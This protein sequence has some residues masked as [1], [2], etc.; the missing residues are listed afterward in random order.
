[1]PAPWQAQMYVHSFVFETCG[2][3]DE[4][5][6]L[7]I[8][9]NLNSLSRSNSSYPIVEDFI[10]FSYTIWQ[11]KVFL[12]LERLNSINEL[13]CDCS[14][15]QLERRTPLTC[16]QSLLLMNKYLVDLNKLS[17]PERKQ[18]LPSFVA[19]SPDANIRTWRK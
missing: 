12:I 15:G 16:P 3:M 9:Y 4:H 7:D 13:G 18:D 17:S 8:I 6:S 5:Q 2:L 1:M 10:L 14:T 19:R 11:K